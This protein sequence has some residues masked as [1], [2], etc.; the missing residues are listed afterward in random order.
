MMLLSQLHVEA[1]FLPFN[2]IF[3]MLFLSHQFYSFTMKAKHIS[4]I[5]IIRSFVSN[6]YHI[7][8]QTIILINGSKGIY[9]FLSIENGGMIFKLFPFNNSSSIAKNKP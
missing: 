7:Y 6:A 5:M 1:D 8:C 9:Y 3:I 4:K 2:L